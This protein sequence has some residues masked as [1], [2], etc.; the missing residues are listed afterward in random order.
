MNYLFR[1]PAEERAAGYKYTQVNKQ[2][3]IVSGAPPGLMLDLGLL[4]II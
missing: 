2:K 1:T 4:K 3:L